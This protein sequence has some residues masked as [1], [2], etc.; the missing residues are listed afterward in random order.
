MT[1]IKI[2]GTTN[3]DDALLAVEAGADALG[4]VFYEK[5]PRYVT[6][7]LAREIVRELPK[8]VEAVGVFVN[9]YEDDILDTAARVGLTA[10]QMHGDNEDPHVADLVVEKRPDLSVFAAISMSNERPEGSAMM[11]DPDSVRAFLLDSARAEKRGGTGEVFDWSGAK[12]SVEVIKT[13]GD[14]V[15]AGGLTPGNV[16]QAMG[17]LRPWGVD[18]VSGV[19][20]TAGKKDS[21]KVRAFVAAV[22]EAEREQ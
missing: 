2:C 7:E 21:A 6:P 13:L 4:F 12:R 17:V 22:R 20:R 18:V 1:W 15:V 9:K 5:S 14:I 10:V 8:E 16:A 19:E 11:Y 3:L